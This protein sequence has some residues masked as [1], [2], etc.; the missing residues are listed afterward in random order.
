[1]MDDKHSKRGGN[2]N[3]IAIAW[4]LERRARPRPDRVHAA[5]C[6]R[7]L[8]F[9]CTVHQRG[10]QRGRDL[11]CSELQTGRSQYI[12]QLTTA[13]GGRVPNACPWIVFCPSW[14][15]TDL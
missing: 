5:S 3:E 2:K 9:C 13:S 10:W 1:M 12:R 7:V 14:E 6:F 8:G 11:E 4:P 15:E